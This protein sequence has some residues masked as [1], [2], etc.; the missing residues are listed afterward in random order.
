MQGHCAYTDSLSSFFGSVSSSPS[1]LFETRTSLALEGERE[2]ERER[3]EGG[4]EREREKETRYKNYNTL[5]VMY[6]SQ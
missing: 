1:A 4:R 3:E 6:K 2:R 5:F